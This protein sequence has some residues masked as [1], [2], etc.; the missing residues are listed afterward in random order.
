MVSTYFTDRS[1]VAVPDRE[2]V[3]EP[4]PPT[5]EVLELPS[6]NTFP[7]SAYRPFAEIMAENP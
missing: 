1:T 6:L 4:L 2:C 3:W 7:D 5:E